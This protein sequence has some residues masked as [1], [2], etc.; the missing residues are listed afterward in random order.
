MY[1]GDANFVDG[2]R[3]DVASGF[4]TDP[5]STRAGWGY[6]LL[7]NFLPNGN[8]TFNLHAIAHN[9]YGQSTDLG[10]KTIV[11]DNVHAS[12]PFGTIDT[13]SQGG[14]VSGNSYDNFGWALTQNPNCIAVDGSTLNVFVDGVP[15][16]HPAY[17]QFRS[18]IATLF[19]GRCNSNGGVGFFFIDTTTLTNGVHTI[20]WSV[21]DNVGHS[22]GI[23][24]RYFTV[25]NSGGI[26][27]PADPGNSAG[28]SSAS[29]PNPPA[30][31]V[32]RGFATDSQAE[33]LAAEPD[34]SYTV[35]M[36]ET[37][38]IEMEIGAVNVHH[39]VNGDIRGLP[40]GSTLKEGIFSW[41]VGPGFLGR[42][43]L[44]FDRPDGSIVTVR[45]EIQ[46]KAT[47]RRRQRE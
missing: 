24:S 22:D 16:G 29:M 20:S 34:G 35:T 25:F 40:T 2:A 39:M 47:P 33:A 7:T 18:D 36:E 28:F 5:F 37:G 15:I 23:G 10:V 41:G 6:M 14:T 26:A 38:R 11:V 13:P 30:I 12:K 1:I 9:S 19:A 45:V 4:P 31:T 27:A 8:G 32:R 17:N 21:T 42:H 3:P 44:R 46:P 43:E